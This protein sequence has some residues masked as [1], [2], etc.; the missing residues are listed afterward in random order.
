MS[1]VAETLFTFSVE[2][3]KNI[4]DL[5]AIAKEADQ[6]WQSC[7]EYEKCGSNIS[8]RSCSEKAKTLEAQFMGFYNLA[9]E[10]VQ[11][12]LRYLCEPLTHFDAIS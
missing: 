8:A 1:T 11:K 6:A 10:D 4:A 2:D 7:G 5:Y 9:S 3:L 12:A